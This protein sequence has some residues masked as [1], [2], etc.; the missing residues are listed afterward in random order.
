MAKG[1]ATK[2]TTFRWGETASS[3]SKSVRIKSFPDLGGPPEMIEITD[4]SDEAQ[5]FIL[6]VQSMSAMEFTANFTKTDFETVQAD[7][8][9]DLYYEIEFGDE[10]TFEWQGQHSVHVT[11]GGVNEAVE[12]V[13]TVAPT[14]KPTL[15]VG[16]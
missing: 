4:L 9:K 15:K 8:G 12:M 10:A 5:S 2:N 7:A 3:L 11:G 16:S 6:G 13:I 1:I 14:T